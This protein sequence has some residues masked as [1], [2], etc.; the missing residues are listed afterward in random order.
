MTEKKT[1]ATFVALAMVSTAFLSIAAALPPS[2]P[3]G[4]EG[5][6][7]PRPLDSC[8]DLQ[9]LG[10]GGNAAGSSGGTGASGYHSYTNTL[11]QTIQG[12]D[13]CLPQGAPDF[14]LCTTA[15]ERDG[16]ER[17]VPHIVAG[18]TS[19]PP[20][21][22]LIQTGLAEITDPLFAA[23][24]PEECGA[25]VQET[26]DGE[27]EWGDD[28]AILNVRAGPSGAGG[29]LEACFWRATAHHASDTTVFVQDLVAGGNVG[30]TVAADWGSNGEECGDGA[31]E[32]CSGSYLE[33]LELSVC[34]PL[35]VAEHVDAA[36]V[37]SAYNSWTSGTSLASFGGGGAAGM[38]TVFLDNGPV[39]GGVET[40]ALSAEASTPSVGWI[41]T[42]P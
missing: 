40:L 39:V 17:G 29:G 3:A 33:R 5:W 1:G 32:P 2:V 22:A 35:D 31:I 26:T 8:D 38:L 37:G 20:D 10:T 36:G 7:G 30:F 14:V 16:I 34:N 25:L 15:P 9:S 21:F 18:A 6:I 12:F 41:W 13:A 24:Y 23:Q 11:G 42:G 4:G 27:L 19:V 28:T